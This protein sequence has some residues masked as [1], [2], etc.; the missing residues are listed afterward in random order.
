[1]I[2]NISNFS[3][4]CLFDFFTD[5]QEA[6][7]EEDEKCGSHVEALKVKLELQVGASAARP[8]IFVWLPWISRGGRLYQRLLRPGSP[9]GT[10][11]ATST[12]KLLAA[13]SA[14]T[15]K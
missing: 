10:A 11:T 15:I 7:A 1:M 8:F 2:T 5:G 13:R 6:Q 14:Y 4:I 3:T 9:N 12:Q